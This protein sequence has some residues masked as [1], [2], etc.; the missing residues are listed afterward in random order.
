V[1]LLDFS[2]VA[3]SNLHQQLKQSKKDPARIVERR[4]LAQ[5]NDVEE[6]ED[7]GEVNPSMLRH[8]ILNS[9]RRINKSYRKRFGRL[10]IATDNHNYW[11]KS[12]FQY[13]KAN[14]KKDRDDSGI[15]WP[16]VFSILN[17]LR[18]EIKENFPYKVMDVPGAEAD[19]VIGVIA[20]HF[21]DNENILIVSGDKDF[22]QLQRYEGV[23]QY[24]PV[25]DKMLVTEDPAKFLFEHILH[26]D[27]G[28]G[29]PNFLSPDDC[30]VT[31]VRQSPVYQVKIDAW[32]GQPPEIFCDGNEKMLVNYYRN[33][34][35]VDLTEIPVEVEAAILTEFNVPPVGAS[36]KIFGYLVRSRM[37][38][39]LESI[40]EF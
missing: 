28:D 21:H 7:N 40:R 20:K 17:D 30:L 27:K 25:Q 13:Y 39:L 38:N 1:I 29:V 4:W 5:Q 18:D 37:R 26:G 9:I 10:V 34:K 19:D 15:D 22:Q 6:E 8:M 32:Y 36:E 2:Q 35:M 12:A 16:L 3:I 24:G 31:G 11:R 14:R 33:K 23:S